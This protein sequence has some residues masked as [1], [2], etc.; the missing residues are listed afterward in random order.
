MLKNYLKVTLRNIGKHKA[1]SLINISGL[2]IGMAACV[3]ILLYVQD[4]ISFDT[5]HEKGANI[6]RVILDAAVMDQTIETTNTSAPMARVLVE[7]YPE[8]LDAIRFNEAGR[9]LISYEDQKFYE[10]R[11][12]WADSTVFDIFT[13]PLVQGNP[14]TALTKP[15]TVVISEDMARKYF[16]DDDPLGQILRYNN[17]GDYEITGVLQN[18]PHNSHFGFDFLG[19][20]ITL[21][22]ATSPV[23]VSNS[24]Y[25]YLLLQE[26]Y[27]PSNL[28]AKFPEL[29]RKYVAPQIEQAIGQSYDAAVEAG[30][31]WGFYL[32]NLGDIY[33]HSSAS[34][35]IERTGDIRYVY[36]LSAIALIILLIACINFMNLA[37][38]RSS[39]RAREVGLRKVMGSERSQLIW[40]FL[41]E[42][43]LMAVIA[44]V[45]AVILIWLVLPAFNNIADKVLVLEATTVVSMIG[46]A[47]VVGLGSGIYP[48]FVLSGFQPVVVLKGTFSSGAKRSWM[49]SI[50]V[51]TQF[52]I[53]IALLVGTGIVF[54][55]LNFMQN[56]DLGFEQEQVVIL[57]LETQEAQRSFEAF[58]SELIRHTGVVNAAASTG[59]PGHIH[60]NTA[61][62]QEGARDEDVFLAAQ[63][64]ATYDYIETLGIEM[65]A[66]RDFSR[67]FSA[68]SATVIVNEAAVVQMGWDPEE[69]IGKMLT[70]VGSGDDGDPDFVAQIIGVMK[71]FHFVSLH[72]EIYPM[73]VTF[74]QNNG[75]YLPVRIRAENVPETLSFLQ[76][77]WQAFEPAHPYRYYF[78]DEDFGRFYE[79]EER[80]SQ[81]YGYFTVLAIFIACL[82]LF[83]LASFVTEQRTKEIG[84]R[85]VMGASVPGVVVMLSKEFTRLVLVATVIAFPVAYFVMDRWLQDFAYKIDLGAGVFVLSGLL[86]LVVAWLTVSYQSIKAAV[87]NPVDSL[88]YE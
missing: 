82:G 56:K 65:V 44:L 23:W 41:G 76:E 39:N 30:L 1:Y 25:T 58:R 3:L 87:A 88:R 43:V 47:L 57:P 52:A 51:V 26:G 54:Q 78:L 83:G 31:R 12:Y 4:E 81:I 72:E 67:E 74:G 36:I 86:A 35:Q 75:F 49:R 34:D 45:L 46:F 37:T 33:L 69:T 32:E 59:L 80:L 11:F 18:I 66:G 22:R 27:N 61:F 29:V 64:S 84:V 73:V 6:Y 24:F 79:Q 5:Y 17:R 7:E 42:A 16:G 53:S 62:R 85:K 48:A 28:E 15:N 19:S 21:P 38:A 63:L 14:K 10:E 2:A 13:F 40:Q 71:D 77:K 50:L 55:Q 60:N 20:F 68:D 9:V 70:M 8:V